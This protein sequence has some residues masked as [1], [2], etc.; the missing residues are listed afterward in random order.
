MRIVLQYMVLGGVVLRL[1][2]VES[3][4]AKQYY[5]IKSYRKD[6]HSTSKIVEKLGTHEELLKKHADPEAWQGNM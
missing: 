4:N 5:V 6:G 2:I 1:N 3:K